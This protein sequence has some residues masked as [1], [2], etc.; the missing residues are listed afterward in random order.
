MR[1]EKVD[2]A[3]SKTNGPSML[4]ELRKNPDMW[5]MIRNQQKTGMGYAYG[6]FVKQAKL[7]N[8]ARTNMVEALT[9][10]VMNNVDRISEVM[11]DRKTGQEYENVFAAEETALQEKLKEVL[12]PEALSQYQ[13]YT[14]NLA[15]YLTAE[16]F[17]EKMTGSV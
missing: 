16:Q 2:M 17:K 11:R 13:D 12:G 7:S 15:G 1:Q 9:D 8:E 10:Y 6:D 4:S 14:R 5:K 3:A